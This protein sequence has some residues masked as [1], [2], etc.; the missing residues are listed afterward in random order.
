LA[1]LCLK[2]RLTEEVSIATVVTIAMLEVVL[3]L[4]TVTADAVA[5]AGLIELQRPQLG[6]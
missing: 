2:L 4:I 1:S 3:A 5:A 6:L